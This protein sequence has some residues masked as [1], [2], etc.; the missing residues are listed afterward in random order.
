[1]KHLNKEMYKTY[2]FMIDLKVAYKKCIELYSGNMDHLKL[3][4]FGRDPR[5]VFVAYDTFIKPLVSHNGIY[6]LYEWYIYESNII[7]TTN[8]FSLESCK[9]FFNA[10]FL[11]ITYILADEYNYHIESEPSLM[12]GKFFLNNP[13]LTWKRLFYKRMDQDS[14]MAKY[15][16]TPNYRRIDL[17]ANYEDVVYDHENAM[18]YLV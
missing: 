15:M 14:Y 1:M 16:N 7:K 8:P 18:K 6:N 9:K 2:E 12:S 4:M 11:E 17:L 3:V 5:F 13:H 10:V